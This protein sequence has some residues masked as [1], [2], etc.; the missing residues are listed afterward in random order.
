MKVTE[1]EF[2]VDT[3]T[4]G[5]MIAVE[6]ASGKDI[7]VLLSRSGHRRMVAVYVHQLRSSAQPPS[8][9]SLASLRVLGD[10]PSTSDSSPDG[11]STG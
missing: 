4:L 2:D 6:E 7:A 8:W 5:E 3:L 10:L 9:Q 1:I 11:G